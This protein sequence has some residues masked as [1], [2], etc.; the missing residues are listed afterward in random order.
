MRRIRYAVANE[1]A[2][3]WPAQS[4]QDWHCFAGLWGEI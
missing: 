1:P 2:S 3:S 4:L